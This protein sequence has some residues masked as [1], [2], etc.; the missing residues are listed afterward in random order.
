MRHNVTMAV[1]TDIL[2]ANT[3]IQVVLRAALLSCA[4]PVARD[5]V[6]RACALVHGVATTA[7]L[8]GGH[9]ATAIGTTALFFAVDGVWNW[10]CGLES[11]ANAAHHIVGGALCVFALAAESWRAGHVFEPM[12]R[13]FITMEVTNPI[14]HLA[15]LV[16]NERPDVWAHARVRAPLKALLLLSWLKFRIWDI[17]RE[18]GALVLNVRN[19]A[20]FWTAGGPPLLACGVAMLGLQV[21]WLARL[22]GAAVKT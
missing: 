8:V 2:V 3:W 17:G 19:V 16:R 1:S 20:F 15:V 13:A 5:T 14:L 18:L 10:T 12:T 7:L 6:G 21:Y 4:R 22:A 9:T 11:A